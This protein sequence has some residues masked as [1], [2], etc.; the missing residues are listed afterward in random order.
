MTT[1]G[2]ALR[3]ESLPS[4]REQYNRARRRDA[5]GYRE[6]RLRVGDDVPLGY[7]ERRNF[8]VRRIETRLREWGGK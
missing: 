6:L 7:R 1:R 5:R 4:V 3:R 8:A 2:T